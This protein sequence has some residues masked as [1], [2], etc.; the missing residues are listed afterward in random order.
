MPE[1]MQHLPKQIRKKPLKYQPKTALGERLM[2][3]RENAI[4]KGLPLLNA[5]EISEEIRR[6]RGDIE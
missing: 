4:A 1:N 6:R 2:A 3:I 5:D